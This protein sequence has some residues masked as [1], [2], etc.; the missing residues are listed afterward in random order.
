MEQLAPREQMLKRHE[1]LVGSAEI[2]GD[3]HEGI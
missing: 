2:E 1:N 3:V